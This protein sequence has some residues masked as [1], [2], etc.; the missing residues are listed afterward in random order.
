[1]EPEESDVIVQLDMESCPR[2]Q[3]GESRVW[4]HILK[5]YCAQ[6]QWGCGVRYGVTPDQSMAS[7]SQTAGGG[8]SKNESR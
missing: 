4:K 2:L 5:S 3:Q 6:S 7:R 1:M 8:D